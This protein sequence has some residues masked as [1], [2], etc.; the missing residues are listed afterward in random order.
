MAKGGENYRNRA[1]PGRDLNHHERNVQGILSPLCLPIPPPGRGM[2]RRADSNRCIKVLQTS[3]LA[4][5]VRRRNSLNPFLSLTA[6]CQLKIIHRV[7]NFSRGGLYQNAMEPQLYQDYDINAPPDMNRLSCFLVVM[8]V[9]YDWKLLDYY[10]ACHFTIFC[11]HFLQAP[12][13]NIDILYNQIMIDS[14]ET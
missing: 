6:Y 12:F 14:K 7:Q 2:R 5:W 9:M 11:N 3:P 4:T 13:I 8:P 10:I 1:C